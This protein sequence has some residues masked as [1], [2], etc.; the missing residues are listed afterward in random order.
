M[1][2]SPVVYDTRTVVGRYERHTL[3]ERDAEAVE[4]FIAR[5]LR[6]AH[7]AADAP[8]DARTILGVAHMFADELTVSHP[9]FDRLAFVEAATEDRS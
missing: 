9:G 1:S 2:A 4:Q 3:V 8:S 7:Q 5:V 6:Q